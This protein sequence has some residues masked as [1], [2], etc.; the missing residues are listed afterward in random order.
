M[1]IT[2]Y[3]NNSEPNKIRKNLA[4]ISTVDG[5]LRTQSSVIDPVV[6]IEGKLNLSRINYMYIDGFQR[7]YFIRDIVSLRTGIWEI[8]A[9]VD[10]LYTYANE[11]LQL[12]CVIGRNEYE[13]NL[14]LP[15]DRFIV[16]ANRLVQTVE[17]PYKFPTNGSNYIITISGGASNPNNAT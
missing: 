1:K 9:H 3:F 5:T 7:Y 6:R 4:E 11:L 17:F 15:D 13:Y 14:F 10:V 16:N 2:L 12:P 8:S